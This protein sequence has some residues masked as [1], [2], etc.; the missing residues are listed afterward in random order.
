MV[1]AVLVILTK[2]MK[3]ISTSRI[4]MKVTCGLSCKTLM[5]YYSN[6]N[7]ITVIR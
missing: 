7:N 5:Y 1:S 2:I 3:L 4:L 6:V